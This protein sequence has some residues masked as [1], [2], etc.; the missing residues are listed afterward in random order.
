MIAIKKCKGCGKELPLTE[1]GRNSQG[2]QGYHSRCRTCRK[3]ESYKRLYGISLE[4]AQRILDSQGG[5]CALCGYPLDLTVG[6]DR[7]ACVDHC[8][9]TGKIRGILCRSCNG[10]IGK[11]G[12]SV[13]A[14]QKVINYL[15]GGI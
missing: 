2:R 8:H 9:S 11:L 4:D 7:N 5:V 10:A 14:M 1:Y 15:Q 12:D 3:S 13:E 6:N